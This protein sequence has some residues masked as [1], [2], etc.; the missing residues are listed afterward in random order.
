LGAEFQPPGNFDP[1]EIIA[2]QPDLVVFSF[3]NLVVSLLWPVRR[4]PA[5]A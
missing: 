5:S 2:F 1:V 4:H 3:G